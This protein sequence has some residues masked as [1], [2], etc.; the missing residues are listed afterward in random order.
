[1]RVVSLPGCNTRF[2]GT[3]NTDYAYADSRNRDKL[4]VRNVHA[5]F[6]AAR[7]LNQAEENGDPAHEPDLRSSRAHRQTGRAENQTNGRFAPRGERGPLL[8]SS[9]EHGS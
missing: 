8:R 4:R 9:H 5:S 6:R 3:E 2:G 1:M 7:P